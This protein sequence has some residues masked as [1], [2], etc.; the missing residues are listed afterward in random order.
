MPK[1]I[2]FLAN[3]FNTLYAFRRELIRRLVSEGNEV[4][5]SLPESEDNIFFVELGCHVVVTKID[6]RGV[7][8]VKDISLLLAYRRILRQVNPDI[9]FS[10]TIKPNIYGSLVSNHYGYRQICNITGTGATFLK[11][12]LVSKICKFLY[13]ISV[14]KCHK[15]FFQ[16]RGD[17]EFF[18]KNGLVKDNYAQLPG[19]GCNINEFCYTPIVNDGI[20]RFF[21]IGRVMRLK[22]IDEFLECA[23]AIKTKYPNTKFL[24]A[25]WNE[26]EGSKQKVADYQAKGIVQYIGF[27]KN[28]KEWISK[29][30]CTVLASHGGEGVPNVVLESAA[31]GRPCIVSNVNGSVDVVEDGKTGFIFEAGNAKDLIDKVEKFLALSNEQRQEMGFA[32]REKVER[33]FDRE[34]VINAYLKELEMIR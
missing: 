8:P 3:H 25:G 23:K 32:G 11:E 34:I 17:K 16:N 2:L 9:I 24:I 5:L 20:V 4:Y 15:V 7:N 13:K 12:S 1:R 30:Q 19:S 18:I 6:R 27:S 29:T 33:E 31:M 14:K 26:E 21:F 10:Y 28:I 22:G